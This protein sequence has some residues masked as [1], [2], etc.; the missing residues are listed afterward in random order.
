MVPTVTETSFLDEDK[1][2]VTIPVTQRICDPHYKES[3][4]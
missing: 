3:R 4:T 1:E 2:V